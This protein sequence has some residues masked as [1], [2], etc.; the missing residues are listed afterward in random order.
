MG[1]LADRIK[2]ITVEIGGDTTGLSKAL[3]GVNKEISSTQ[4]ELKDVERLLKMDPGN[5]EL[6][7]QK[8]ELL[9]KSIDATENKLDALKE[10][11]K[12]VQAQ[13]E[14]GDIGESQYNALRREIIATESNLRKLKSEAQQTQKKI[15]DVNEKPIEDVAKAADDAE[16]ELKDAGKEASN[17]GDY[18]RAGAVIEEIKGIANSIAELSE[19]TKEYR[20]VM[21]SLEVSS[22]NAGYTA[23]ETAESYRTLYSVLGDDQTAATT[24]ANLQAIGLSQQDLRTAIHATIGAWATYGDSIP[25]DSLSEAI[26]ET[27]QTGKVTGTFADVLNWAGISED[28]FNKKLEAANSSTERAKIVLQQMTS[29]GLDKAGKAWQEN[30]KDITEANKNTLDFQ[31]SLAELSRRTAPLTNSIQSGINGILKKSLDLTKKVDFDKF[32]REIDN[33]FDFLIDKVVPTVFDFVDFILENKNAGIGAITGV[34]AALVSMKAVETITKIINVTKQ[35]V[36]AINAAKTAQQLWNLAMNS[37]VIGIVAS[38]I[39]LLVGGITALC[40]ETDEATEAQKRQREEMELLRTKSEELAESYNQVKEASA[41]KAMAD[42]AEIE[43]VKNLYSELESLVDANGQ[44][45]DANKGRA[46]FILG[47]LNEAL[48]TEYTMTGNQIN[49]YL[50]MK[51]SIYELIEAK[52]MEILMQQAEENYTK[53][54]EKRTEAQ[55]LFAESSRQLNETEEELAR[56]REQRAQLYLEQQKAAAQGGEMEWIMAHHDELV[57]LEYSIEEQEKLLAEKQAAYD[58][59]AAALD[60]YYTDISLYVEAAS[61]AMSGETQKVLDLL[62]KQN[63]GFV[64]AKDLSGKTEKEKKEVLGEQYAKS[65]E[66]LENYAK[67][68]TEGT[69]G[70]TEDTLKILQRNA[71][72]AKKEWDQVASDSVDGYIEGINGRKWKINDTIDSLFKLIP[73]WARDILGSHSPSKVMME[74]GE[75]SG[76]GYDIGLKDSLKKSKKTMTRMFDFLSNMQDSFFSSSDSLI[77]NLFK[78]DTA[79]FKS[80]YGTETLGATSSIVNTQNNSQFYPKNTTNLGGIN[81]VIYGAPGQNVNELANIIMDKI[82]SATQRKAAIYA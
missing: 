40:L 26:N 63:A 47:E 52:R 62:E 19:E 13:F 55:D 69:E 43:N 50:K 68:Y 32:A 21:A 9:N 75:D 38:A 3:S 30:N 81:M 8:Y 67:K 44:V 23:D 51:D 31:E 6:L 35:A 57:N 2:G 48:G 56:L 66:I 58:E 34:G 45:Q 24:T 1:K 22:Q 77:P 71:E 61:L 11:E 54:I 42:L 80:T 10:A 65:L 5:T 27:I 4:K 29:Q 79:S 49:Q 28:E 72:D 76:E 36:T 20:K 82:E 64:E 12:Q 18:L 16:D 74:I 41:S 53:A 59:N 60:Q 7:R 46:S 33:A 37:N 25:I 17:F 39:G 78:L 14:R 15:N 73:S 70:Y